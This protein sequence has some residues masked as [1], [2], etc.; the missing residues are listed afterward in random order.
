MRRGKEIREFINKHKDDLTLV[1]DILAEEVIRNKY[2]KILEDR[3]SVISGLDGLDGDYDF[4]DMCSSRASMCDTDDFMG[5]EEE[6]LDYPPLNS[7]Y[8]IGEEIKDLKKQLKSVKTCTCICIFLTT[9]V[10]LKS[11][12]KTIKR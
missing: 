6:E 10:L 4:I 11:V 5:W 2:G 9:L 8:V 3:L 7:G 1:V 12:K